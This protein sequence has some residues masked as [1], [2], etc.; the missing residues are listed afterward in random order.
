M[1]IAM[2]KEQEEQGFRIT[3]KRGFREDGAERGS[4]PSAD[5]PKTSPAASS[6]ADEKTSAKQ[7]G[8]PRTP[9]DI[10]SYVLGFYGQG[11][12][13]LGAV[14]NPDT[15]KIEENIEVARF[16]ID[17]LTMLEQKTKG[18]L[19]TEEQKFLDDVLYELRMKFMAKTDRIKY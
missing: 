8:P 13:S 11:M 9:I 6:P 12:V 3:D 18:N 4:D 5:A 1:D 19:T 10:V 7:E 2:T 17:V 16:V 14:P 15:N